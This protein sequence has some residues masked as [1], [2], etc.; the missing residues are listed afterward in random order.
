MSKP[1][2]HPKAPTIDH[3]LPISKGGQDVHANIQLA[4]FE[5]NWRKGD[6]G[7]QQLMLVG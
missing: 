1:V 3:I 2:P 4:H 6:G 5:C 7:S